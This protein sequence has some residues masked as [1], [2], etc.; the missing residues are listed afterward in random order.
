MNN[1]TIDQKR[2]I[3]EWKQTIRK[4]GAGKG[5]KAPMLLKQA[6]DIMSKCQGAIPVWIMPLA[7]VVETFDPTKNKFDVLIID[8]ASQADLL[9]LSTLYLGRQIII[10]GDDKQ[11]SP[12]SIGIKDEVLAQL[13]NQYLEKIPSYRLYDDK[14]SIYDLAMLGNF[15]QVVLREHFR[16]YPDI[17]SFS[18]KWY[19]NNRIEPLRDV[20]NEVIKPS[21]VEFRVSNGYREPNTKLNPNEAKATVSLLHAMLSMEE[22]NNKTFGIISM[23]GHEHSNYIR[24]IIFDSID[25]EIIEKRKI[26]V[27]SPSHFQGDERDIILLNLV[28]SSETVRLISSGALDGIHDKEYNVATSRAKDQLWVVHS[29]NP[30][31]DLNVNDLR[32]RL[33]QHIRNPKNTEYESLTTRAES[34]FEKEVMESLLNQGYKVVPQYVVGS[35]RIDMIIYNG[36][37]RVALECDGEKFHGENQAEYDLMRQIQ[38]ERL[39]WN[40]IRLRGSMYYSNKDEGIKYVVE[41]LNT[42]KIYPIKEI[43]SEQKEVKDILDLVKSKALEIKLDD[44]VIMNNNQNIMKKFNNEEIKAKKEDD[45]IVIKESQNVTAHA[46]INQKDEPN[47]LEKGISNLFNRSNEPQLTEIERLEK[48]LSEVQKLYFESIE[49]DKNITK[50]IRGDYVFMNSFDMEE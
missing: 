25:V 27:G 3:N 20:S 47:L 40:F 43:L 39:G 36:D 38:L 8:E 41:K 50:A 11:V 17:I 45:F 46:P 42:L 13:Q 21:V 32:F 26:T 6:R 22:Y 28:D 7:Q 1:L 15:K 5:K 9:A 12:T 37:R 35:Y 18:N 16:C 48:R 49:N 4:L 29:L 31:R 23:L 34:V 10:V 33:I 2:H 14:R 30:E 44:N 19:Y 24:K